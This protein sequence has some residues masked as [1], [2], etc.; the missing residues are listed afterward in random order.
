MAL[1]FGDSFQHRPSAPVRPIAM[2]ATAPPDDAQSPSLPDQRAGAGSSTHM[3]TNG[4]APAVTERHSTLE[5]DPFVELASLIPARDS[6]R[7]SSVTKL[8]AF[9]QTKVRQRRGSGCYLLFTHVSPEDEDAIGCAIRSLD[10]ETTIRLTYAD[11]LETLIVKLMPSRA[12][13]STAQ[14]FFSQVSVK[15]FALHRHTSLS[16]VATGAARFNVPAKGSK[17]ADAGIRPT[18]RGRNDWP[19][20]VFE[21]GYAETLAALCTDARWWLVNSG[22]QTKMVMVQGLP[23]SMYATGVYARHQPP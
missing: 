4:A 9:V 11:G 16:I 1:V 13:E 5:V 2:S 20:F 22:G 12:H 19:S 21:V 23:L 14:T 7:Y 10:L 3:H 17:E 18:T 6:L 15:I 8:Q